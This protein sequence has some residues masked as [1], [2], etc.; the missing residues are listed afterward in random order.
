MTDAII[1]GIIGGLI[2]P[3]LLTVLRHFIIWRAEKYL[4]MKAQIFDEAISAFAKRATDALDPALQ[5]QKANYKGFARETEYR[6]DTLELLER[7]RAQ[8]HAFYLPEAAAK[9]DRA[10]NVKLSID[11]IPNVEFEE[12]RTEAISAL[13]SELGLQVPRWIEALTS[14]WRGTRQKAPR[15]SA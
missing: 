6:P 5:S 4:E 1:G 11:N 7:A 15:P 10:A 14:R 9:F 12:A 13:A 8:V 2:S 3:L